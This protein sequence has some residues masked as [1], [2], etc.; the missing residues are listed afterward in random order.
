MGIYI[1]A[2][3]TTVFV[4]ALYGTIIARMS[5][6]TDWPVLLLAA[7]VALPLQPLAYYLVRLP[8]NGAL[9]ATLGAGA[10]LTALTL[11]YAP[12]TEE[13]AK[14]LPLLV[15]PIRRRLRPDNAVAI[16]LAVGLGFGIGEIWF[17]AVQVAVVPAYAGLPFYAFGGF[18]IERALVCFLHGAMISFAYHRLATGR[19]FLVGGLIGMA[20]HFMLNLPI[21]LAAVDLF[22]IGA[23]AWQVVLTFWAPGIALVLGI[24]VSKL[25]RGRFRA[26]VLGFSTCPECGAEYPRPLLAFNFGPVRYE[27]CPHCRHFHWV[28]IG[29]GRA[30]AP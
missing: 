16:A 24:A 11:L 9:T 14:W 28:R 20:L 10:L 1:A 27:R 17:L 29:K 22:G 15:P 2:A 3:I 7:V 8:L 19:S 25:T 30:P 12:L 13:P 21:F 4:I 26:V 23:L 6:R 5:A 18:L